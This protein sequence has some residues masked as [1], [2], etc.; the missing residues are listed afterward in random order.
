[1]FND[2]KEAQDMKVEVIL[3]DQAG[4]LSTWY[5]EEKRLVRKLDRRILP[6]AC[7]LYLFAC[8]SY[9]LLVDMKPSWKLSLAD[10]DRSNLGNARFLVG[11]HDNKPALPA[12]GESCNQESENLESRFLGSFAL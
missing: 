1:M 5:D 3:E 12:D 6:I 2:S 8:Q 10:L 11:L 9:F 7:L 4:D